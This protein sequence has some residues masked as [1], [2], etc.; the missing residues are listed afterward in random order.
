MRGGGIRQVREVARVWKTEVLE[1]ERI[2]VTRYAEYADGG[3]IQDRE[4][5]PYFDFNTNGTS[6][7]APLGYRVWWHGCQRCGAWKKV[8]REITAN[9]PDLAA[10]R[11]AMQ[12]L[13]LW[14]DRWM[15]FFVCEDCVKLRRRGI[16]RDPLTKMFI[17]WG[18]EGSYPPPVHAG[19]RDTA[20]DMNRFGGGEPGFTPS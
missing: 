2:E 18:P 10:F 8:I 17:D 13:V 11:F 9:S 4:R 19:W 3:V 7:Q 12:V 20:T 15:D 14:Q 1:G 5:F 6:I 16:R